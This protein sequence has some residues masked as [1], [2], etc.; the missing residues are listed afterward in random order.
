MVDFS[1]VER[2]GDG[3]SIGHSRT[4]EYEVHGKQLIKL[5]QAIK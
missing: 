3:A 4:E 2:L 5:K 1:Y